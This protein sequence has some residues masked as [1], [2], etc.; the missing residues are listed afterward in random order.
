[1]AK[2]VPKK[3]KTLRQKSSGHEADYYKLIKWQ[4]HQ[5]EILNLYVLYK[6]DSK[7]RN[8]FADL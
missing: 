2:S 1:M 4:N 7:G 3:N 6:T 5:E 8:K